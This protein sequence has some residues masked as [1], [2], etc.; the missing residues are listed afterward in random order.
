VN[1]CTSLIRDKVALILAPST[2]VFQATIEA[3]ETELLAVIIEAEKQFI[4]SLTSQKIGAILAQANKPRKP[5]KGY[6]IVPTAATTPL[7]TPSLDGEK[8]GSL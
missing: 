6:I 4:R 5:R 7:H 8:G 2:P 1:N 3:L